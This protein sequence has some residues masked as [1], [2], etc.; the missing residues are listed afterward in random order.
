MAKEGRGVV[1]IT[2]RLEEVMEVSDR[3]TVLRLGKK[4]GTM[5]TSKTTRRE[6]AKMMMGAEVSVRLKRKHVKVGKPALELKDLR[7]TSDRG[8]PAV[9]GITLSVR[10]GEILGI[11]GVSG[12]GQRELVEAITGLRNVEGGK[13]LI[14]G[15]DMTNCSPR[16]IADMDVAHIPE[17]RRRIGTA[18]GMTVAE[19]IMMRDY[20][21]SPFC[22]WLLLKNSL[23]TKH[24]EKMVSEYEILTPDLWQSETRILSGGNIQRLILARETWREPRLIIAVH[25][26]YG[27][28]MK[29]LKHTHELFLRLKGKGTAI[30]LVSEDVDE[31]MSLSDRIAVIFEGKIVGTVDAAKAKKVEIGLM[32]A[33]SKRSSRR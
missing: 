25:P 16:K 2:H 7:V 22:K 19:N 27:L 33:G 9:R 30:L 20:R 31:I 5:E 28:D 14:F 23:I 11:A 8:L 15:R 24:S 26:T 12:N 1:F 32:M 6:L 4:V 29:A 10:G 17:E 13:V 21:K 18:E 3:V